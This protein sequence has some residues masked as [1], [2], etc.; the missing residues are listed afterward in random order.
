MSSANLAEIPRGNTSPGVNREI[1]KYL[2]SLGEEFS[3]QHFL[4]LPC[5]QGLFLQAAK[6]FFPNI[7][8]VGGDISAPTAG[9]SHKFLPIN[10]QKDFLLETENKFKV[11]T[12]ISGVMEFD[13]TLAFFEKLKENLAG[14]GLLIISNDNLLS[15][16]DRVLYLLFGRFR[17]YH[18][19]I[20]HDRP[21]WKTISLQNLLRILIEAGFDPIEIRYVPPLPGEWMWLPLAFPIYIF[22]YLYFLLAEKNISVIEKRNLYPFSSLLARHYFIVCRQKP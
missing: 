13:N 8:T 2:L 6:N 20:P 3:G 18:L 10:A 17:Q 5:G 19:F 16:R 4:D 21:T 1:I 9:F 15:V 12:C 7:E 22:Q 14:T 11:I